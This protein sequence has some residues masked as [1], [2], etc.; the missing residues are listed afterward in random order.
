VFD[1]VR[2]AQRV[3]LKRAQRIDDYERRTECKMTGKP[4]RRGTPA[5]ARKLS[6]LA[7]DWAL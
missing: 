1:S 3:K 7:A 5:A 6:G 4:T 2:L